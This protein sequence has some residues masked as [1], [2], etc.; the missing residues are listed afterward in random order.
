M[1]ENQF[2]SFAKLSFRGFS[3]TGLSFFSKMIQTKF[4]VKLSPKSR[5]YDSSTRSIWKGI[6]QTFN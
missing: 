1:R 5:N 6:C 4:V 2:K 3:L